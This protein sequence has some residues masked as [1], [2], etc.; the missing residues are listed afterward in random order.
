M[1]LTLGLLPTS[2]AVAA[3]ASGGLLAA[4]VAK[5]EAAD[6][7]G[8]IAVEG[9]GGWLFLGRDLQHL[10]AG[11]FWGAEAVKV[12]RASKPEWAD[13]LPAILDFKAQLDRLG[14]ELLLLPV[15]PKGVIYPDKLISATPPGLPLPRLDAAHQE[16]YQLLREKGVQVLDLTEPMLA[17]RK[18]AQ[19]PP[20]YCK[21]DTHWSAFAC[22]LA[23][24]LIRQ[25][26]QGQA[27]YKPSTNAAFAGKVS[28]LTFLGDLEKNL[29]GEG[30]VKETLRARVVGGPETV[31]SASPVLLLG[32]SHCL[33]FHAGDDM[34][35]TGAGLADQLALELGRPV[36]LLGTRGSGATPARVNL[37]QRVKADEKYLP[38][39]KLVIWCFA[40]REFTESS[41]WRKV[42]LV[43]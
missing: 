43:K 34:L 40:A 31:S 8:R 42:P 13:P 3:G 16:F 5:A 4:V 1:F 2:A 24:R 29:R 18:D 14:I 36:D 25:H 23:A 19:G 21:T 32:D 22:E 10:N 9:E 28:E 38:A 41:G 35:A 20:P 7:A 15:P 11:R 39:K 37:L 6:Q 30:G 17:A 12:S 27:W 33:V 26:V